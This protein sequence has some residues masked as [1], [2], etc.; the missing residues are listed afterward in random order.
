MALLDELK[1]ILGCLQDLDMKKGDMLGKNF[2]KSCTFYL[3]F[4][5]F[6]HYK[7]CKKLKIFQNTTSQIFS[8]VTFWKI[9]VVVHS[10]IKKWENL[11]CGVFRKFN[12]KKFHI[13]I[14]FRLGGEAGRQ[15][16]SWIIVI[17][18]FFVEVLSWNLAW[19]SSLTWEIQKC[20]QNCCKPNIIFTTSRIYVFFGAFEWNFH[21]FDGRNSNLLH[22]AHGYNIK[23]VLIT[24]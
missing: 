2:E 23:H 10:L 19:E 8:S 4:G 16:L 3:N 9:W 21:Q 13:L 12:L 14:F 22:H 1:P 18:S 15:G 7:F 11:A 17:S 24:S 20:H 6:F 5:S